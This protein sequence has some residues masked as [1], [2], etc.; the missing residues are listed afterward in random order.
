MSK[1]TIGIVALEETMT[2]A[3]RAFKGETQGHFI[4]FASH[5]LMLKT[6]TAKRWELIRALA[7]AG[8]M[9][10]RAA[11]RRMGRDVK[12]V[13]G[14]IQI[15]LKAGV[16]EKDERQRIVFPYDEIHVDFVLKAA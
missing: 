14:D 2:R 16:L 8:P 5:E 11:A 3:R 1:V 4:G 12:S 9:S 7:G 15:L 10:V 6:L 13:H